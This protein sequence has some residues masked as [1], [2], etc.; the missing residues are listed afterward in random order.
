MPAWFRSD[1]DDFTARLRAIPWAEYETAYGRADDVPKILGALVG[2]NETAALKAAYE[3]EATLCHQHVR[4]DSAALPALPFLL[5][6]SERAAP[7]VGEE[8]M[9]VIRGMAACARW[10]AETSPERY[11]ALEWLRELHAA[12]IAERPRWEALEH[13][14]NPEID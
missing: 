4:I 3:L 9:C 8:I 2:R 12:L 10:A 6:A 14:P 13:H 7:R 11:A 5:E 1:Q